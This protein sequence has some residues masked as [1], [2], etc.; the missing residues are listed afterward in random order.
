MTGGE[1]GRGVTEKRDAD[2]CVAHAHARRHV[3]ERVFANRLWL[4]AG[5]R[6]HAGIRV[7][8]V[9]AHVH[10]CAQYCL[11]ILAVDL[12]YWVFVLILL[13]KHLPFGIGVS[14]QCV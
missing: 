5:K 13:Y 9:R 1:T 2:T 6:A 3:H 14:F 10:A 8:H 11:M 12:V 4:H 7:G